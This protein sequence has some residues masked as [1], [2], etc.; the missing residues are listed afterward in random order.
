MDSVDVL[1]VG[2]GIVGGSLAGALGR[3]G[4]S[5]SLLDPRE[6]KGDTG[7]VSREHLVSNR[8]F[9]IRPSIRDFLRRTG[10]WDEILNSR[11]QEVS[12]MEI[13][14]KRGEPLVFDAYQAGFDQLAT[15]V[16]YD[17]LQ[18]AILETIENNAVRIDQGRFVG[19]DVKEDRVFVETTSGQVSCKLL[20]GAD[21][22]HS[23]VRQ[24]ANIGFS[25]HD[26]EF[27]GVV[28]S[29][30][31]NRTH[32][33]VAYQKFVDQSVIAFL[34]LPLDRAN[35]VWSLKN[36]LAREL[37]E[38][39]IIERVSA[40]F[41]PLGLRSLETSVGKFP[42]SKLTSSTT[43]SK[44]IAL[45]GDSA[46]QFLPLA[47]QGLNVGL[48]DVQKLTEFIV[49]FG[50]GDPGSDAVLNRYRRARREEVE[51]FNLVTGA[52]HE[53][54]ISSQ[55][56]AELFTGTMLKLVNNC[57]LAKQFLVDRAAGYDF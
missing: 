48:S 8:V 32:S 5:V 56:T 25:H 44:R 9:T 53:S 6:N 15:V 50:R 2:G 37:N 21:G 26:Y 12:R 18:G 27:S 16:D 11:I 47:G 31:V 40:L 19:L 22:A 43:C 17:A 33:G 55:Q 20:V 23:A 54:L 36:E 4:V 45:V 3:L 42:L 28:A 34:P 13:Y 49:S 57:R 1:I 52:I 10:I 14:S 38:E 41:N 24:A 51:S 30:S 46:H 35:L 39:N 29:F 7:M